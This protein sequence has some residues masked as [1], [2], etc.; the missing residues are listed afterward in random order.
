MTGPAM[1]AWRQRLG[2]SRKRAAEALGLSESQLIDYE[3]GIK[4]GTGRAALIP[5]HVWLAC[6]ALEHLVHLVPT[7]PE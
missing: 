1:L 4:R 5:K 6:L 3:A 7:S 2:Y